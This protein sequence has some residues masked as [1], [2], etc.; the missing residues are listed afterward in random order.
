MRHPSENYT[1]SESLG[2]GHRISDD[3]LNIFVYGETGHWSPV[4][5]IWVGF[6]LSRGPWNG[7]VERMRADAAW[8][9][10]LAA[11]DPTIFSV[12][13]VKDAVSEQALPA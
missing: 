4:K 5:R 12:A 11:R 3:D 2:Q 7:E 13:G 6:V 1:I 8:S 10:E 9:D